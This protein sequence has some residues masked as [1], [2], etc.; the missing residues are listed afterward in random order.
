[1]IA[2]FFL[3]TILLSSTESAP[4]HI[5]NTIVTT[6]QEHTGKTINLFFSSLLFY[7][8]LTVQWNLDSSKLHQSKKLLGPASP[9]PMYFRL[10]KLENFLASNE[11]NFGSLSRTFQGFQVIILGCLFA[12]CC[13]ART[14]RRLNAAAYKSILRC[15]LSCSNMI[16]L[17]IL[18]KSSKKIYT[19]R[20]RGRRNKLQSCS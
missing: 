1:M 10:P 20:I 19:G 5:T 9:N 2:I 14:P 16:P 3:V 8:K 11:S 6:I 7:K 13:D 4:T 17:Q 12:A 18:T 15:A